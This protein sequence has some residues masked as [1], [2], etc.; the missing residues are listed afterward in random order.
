MVIDPLVRLKFLFDNVMYT[1]GRQ[2]VVYVYL[3]FE[4]RQHTI[5]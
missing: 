5:T 3:S 4:C 2:H 1:L